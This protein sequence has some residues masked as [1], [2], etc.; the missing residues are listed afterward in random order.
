MEIPTFESE[1]NPK[2][3]SFFWELDRASNQLS[4]SERAFKMCNNAS[5]RAKFEAAKADYDKIASR[6]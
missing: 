4:I 5:T 1:F 6:Q 2:D 3:N